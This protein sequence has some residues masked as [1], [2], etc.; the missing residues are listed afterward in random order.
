MN[1]QDLVSQSNCI[2]LRR[3]PRNHPLQLVDWPI[4]Q[5]QQLRYGPRTASRWV[6][7]RLRSPESS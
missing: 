2:T 6:E 5:A 3:N 1:I 7:E 4:S